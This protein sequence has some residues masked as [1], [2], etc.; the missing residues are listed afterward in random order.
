MQVVEYV[1]TRTHSS[2]SMTSEH[3]M[4]Y[5][6]KIYVCMSCMYTYVHAC[7]AW[8]CYVVQPTAHEYFVLHI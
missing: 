6:Y 7:V 1:H 8:M 5:A 2:R 4:L 3:S